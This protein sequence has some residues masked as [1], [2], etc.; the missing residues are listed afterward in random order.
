MLEIDIC[1]STDFAFQ[2]LYYLIGLC[3]ACHKHTN[4]SAVLSKSYLPF[5]PTRN[6]DRMTSLFKLPSIHAMQMYI[7]F[8]KKTAYMRYKTRLELPFLFLYQKYFICYLMNPPFIVV[9]E[10]TAVGCVLRK[11]QNNCCT[12]SHMPFRAEILI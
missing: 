3:L 9:F 10:S 1:K 6:Q 5:K 7:K 4:L 8:C 12:F 2:L 11:P